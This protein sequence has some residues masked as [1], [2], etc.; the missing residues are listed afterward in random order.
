MYKI[1]QGEVG[2]LGALSVAAGQIISS[3]IDTGMS[4]ATGAAMSAIT[5]KQQ[6]DL[7]RLQ[8]KMQR[9]REDAMRELTELTG[10]Q[11][12]ELQQQKTAGEIAILDKLNEL[13]TANQ[14]L[15]GT[16]PTGN[17]FAPTAGPMPPTMMQYMGA[18]VPIPD[19]E[20]KKKRAIYWAVGGGAAVLLVGGVA[21]YLLTRKK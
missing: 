7:L 9:E 18:G 5:K 15:Q 17:P 10:K 19:A 20:A 11:A 16:A 21:M 12:L 2:E 13:N 6:E 8:N 3:V 1:H 14:R 4:F